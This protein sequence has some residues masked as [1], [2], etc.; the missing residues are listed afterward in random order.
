MLR[1]NLSVI[2]GIG[3]WLLSILARLISAW[4]LSWRSVS[5][6]ILGVLLAKWFWVFLAPQATFTTSVADPS[7]GQEEGRI[8]GVTQTAGPA[9]QGAALP[10]V[11]LLGVF[12]ASSGK[13]GFAVMKI[14]A[15]RQVG[16][17]EGEEAAPGTKLVEVHAD[18]VTLERGGMKYRVDMVNKPAEGTISNKIAPVDYNRATGGKK[19]QP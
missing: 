4:P 5:A 8:F 18:H 13:R 1:L 17:A 14:D 2:T 9:N 10:N 15:K 19:N 12:T 7:M 16:V 6:L 3:D 11:Q